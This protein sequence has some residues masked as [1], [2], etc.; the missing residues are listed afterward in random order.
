MSRVN[1]MQSANSNPAEKFFQWKSDHQKFA[2]Y[3]KAESKNVFVEM[4]VKFLA[5][6]SYKTIKGYNA[7]KGARISS[8]EVKSVSKNS[9]EDLKVHYFDEGKSVIAE[10]KW[11]DIKDTVDNAGGKFTES[12]YAML[13]D[14][15]LVNFQ[16]NG[17]ALSTWY[18]FQKNQSDKFFDNWI[19][20]N[21]FKEGK[22][23]KVE[24]TYPVFEWGTTL[25]R[26]EGKLAEACDKKIESYEE[27]YFNGGSVAETVNVGRANSEASKYEAANVDA[28]LQ[29]LEI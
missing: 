6:A 4:P 15:T 1:R 22:Q 9:N 18:E 2:Y 13:P 29:N 12:V 11:S 16:I 26:N 17:A 21:G 23:G 8:N 19:E 14:G 28:D 5:L 3:D 10:G 7:K 25:D 27:S 24:Y 20:V